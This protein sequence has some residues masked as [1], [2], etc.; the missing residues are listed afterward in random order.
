MSLPG[1]VSASSRRRA[2]RLSASCR[3]ACVSAS[4]AARSARSSWPAAGTTQASTSPLRT[5]LPTAGKPFGPASMRPA[6]I[7][8]TRPPRCGSTTT[9]PGSSIARATSAAA[10]GAVSTPSW[11]CAALGRK[12]TPSARRCGVLPRLGRAAFSSPWSWPSCAASGSEKMATAQPIRNPR[13]MLHLHDAGS[14][15]ASQKRP[16][17]AR[18]RPARHR[19]AVATV[20]SQPRCRRGPLLQRSGRRP[21]DRLRHQPAR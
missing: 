4:W 8:W 21:A 16:R 17:P 1:T 13:F 5:R 7:A 20:S 19:Q 10:T 14:V 12:T 18:S 15:G 9:W 2:R 6:S 11:R 3:A